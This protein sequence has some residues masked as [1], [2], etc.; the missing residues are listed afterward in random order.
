MPLAAHLRRSITPAACILAIGLLAACSHPKRARVDGPTGAT[1]SLDTE[2]PTLLKQQDGSMIAETALALPRARRRGVDCSH[3]VQE[4]YNRAGFTY[5][6][7]TSYELF[8]GSAPNF[9]RVSQAQAGDLIAW[10]GH[11]GVIIDPGQ[12]TFYSALR[13][14]PG[15]AHY[16]RP[17]WRRRGQPRLYRYLQSNSAD[18]R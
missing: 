14:G 16:D 9:V 7:A 13:S 1:P 11:V 18:L 4:I 5:R 10:P 17:Y 15:I 2:A 3:L 12:R 8:Q 6:Y